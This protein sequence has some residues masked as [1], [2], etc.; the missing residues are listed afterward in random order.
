MSKGAK[1]TK[2]TIARG[3]KRK[4]KE[5]EEPAP[6]DLKKKR[7]SEKEYNFKRQASEDE[8]EESSLISKYLPEKAAKHYGI[9]WRLIN[10]FNWSSKD[11][12]IYNRQYEK[13][14]IKEYIEEN[15]EGKKSGLMYVC[16]HP[17][18]GKS[19]IIRIILK[20][21]EERMAKDSEFDK[22]FKIFNYNGMI[23]KK[24]YDFSTE[25]I[26]D[27]RFKF[28]GKKSNNLESTLKLT[29][30]VWD[31]GNR[32]QKYFTKFNSVH[33]LIIID[34]V[35][36]LSMTEAAKN[37][38][39][40][41]HSVLKSDT[42]TTIIGIANSVDLLSKVS[43][44]NNK[45]MELV[46]KKW[47]FGP[48]SDSDIIKIVNKKKD[49]FW[50]RY[51]CE[52]DYIDSRALEYTAKKVSK[53][54]GDIRVAFD[55]IKTAFSNIAHQYRWEAIRKQREVENDSNDETCL[56]EFKEVS[57]EDDKEN[58]LPVNNSYVLDPLDP[59]VDFKL[60][61]YLAS[62][63][64][65][66]KSMEVIKTLP[67]QLI[68][69]LKTLVY[70]FEEKSSQNKSFKVNDLFLT[71]AKT[72][73]KLSLPSINI[74]DFWNGL[75]TLEFYSLINYWEGKNPKSGKV[76]LKTDIDEIKTGLFESEV[77]KPRSMNQIK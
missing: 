50:K 74:S 43:Q 18:T 21:F 56:E 15:I 48:Y 32:I 44:Y 62:T 34:E 41:L 35:D 20:E 23:F 8:F 60:I 71:N 14:Q 54:S 68:I 1:K 69:T 63:K 24:L 64:F 61:V 67:S 13:S 30:D 66:L 9:I 36:N 57:D 6:V 28:M 59:K 11:M 76:S 53:V 72:L 65:G 4:N 7:S 49:A 75:K 42:N 5:I 12:K 27:I 19:S 29:D 33:K 52:A 46:E 31:L 26:R 17:G 39:S 47:I 37:F 55:L 51:K 40:F 2:K 22:N 77:L 3:R 70:I 73:D 16:G 45:E 38:I 58:T 25:L 10:E